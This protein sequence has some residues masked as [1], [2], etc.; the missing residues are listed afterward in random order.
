MR[1]IG[2]YRLS[3]YWL[4]F[5]D[6]PAAGQTRSKRFSGG[7][8]WGDVIEL[9]AFDRRLRLLV[10]EAI[11]RFEVAVRS[12]WSNSLTLAHGSHAYLD[13]R[14][15][16]DALTHAKTV[17]Q[18][19]SSLGQSKEVFIA[20]YRRKYV[21]P[22]LPPLWSACEIMSLGQLSILYAET[23]DNSVK[24]AV[25]RELNLPTK[26]V[27]ESVLAVA[28][29]TRNICAHHNRLWNRRFVKRPQRVNRLSSVMTF[30]P[31]P[32]G[33]EV[34]NLIYNTLVVLIEALRPQGG[35]EAWHRD[36]LALVSSVSLDKQDGM[37]FPRGWQAMPFWAPL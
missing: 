9:Y 8:T 21:S 16:R 24:D 18:I 4:P 32:R 31:A 5:E 11:E 33:H 17:S 28:A 34:L 25:A 19:A 26:E 37:G 20:H 27:L 3:A 15:F 7:T 6:P 14:Q 30:E 10:L 22:S 13:Y 29:L 36:L 1:A 12:S 2:Y 23:A 35:L